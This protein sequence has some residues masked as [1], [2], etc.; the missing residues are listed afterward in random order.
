MQILREERNT[1]TIQRLDTEE[2]LETTVGEP[3]RKKPRVDNVDLRREERDVRE[4]VI[5]EKAH[6][7]ISKIHVPIQ[8]RGHI[9]R[10]G[11]L[12]GFSTEMGERSH[13]QQLKDGYRHSNGINYTKQII[14]YYTRVSA[15]G[16]RQQNVRQLAK[17]GF[18]GEDVADTLN[19]LSPAG[20]SNF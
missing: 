6:F 14:E 8:Y 7:N 11:A 2:E 13:K 15:L 10:L 1:H 9:E 17:E 19:L 12:G 18:Y 4:R 16:M 20:K 5:A 3:L